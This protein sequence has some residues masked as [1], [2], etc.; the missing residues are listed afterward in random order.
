VSFFPIF[1]TLPSQ[2]RIS[3]ARARNIFLS[4]YYDPFY[5]EL[6]LYTSRPDTLRRDMFSMSRTPWLSLLN[7]LRHEG[8]RTSAEQLRDNIVI[9]A[10]DWQREFWGILGTDGSQQIGGWPPT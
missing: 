1:I 5:A 2:S 4:T 8:W 6:H 3:M 9:I 7:T 10:E